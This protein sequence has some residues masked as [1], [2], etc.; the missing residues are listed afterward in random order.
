MVIK[1]V[2]VAS[3]TA[4]ARGVTV[5]WAFFQQSECVFEEREAKVPGS[6]SEPCAAWKSV[7]YIDFG[8]GSRLP[9]WAER[10]PEFGLQLAWI[11]SQ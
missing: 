8:F 3:K 5:S 9:A 7:I 2:L 6:L 11:D 10:R 4:I 1:L